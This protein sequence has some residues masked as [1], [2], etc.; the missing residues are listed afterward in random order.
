MIMSIP[1]DMKT[2]EIFLRTESDYRAAGY[3]VERIFEEHRLTGDS[4]SHAIVSKGREKKI[5]VMLRE[6]SFFSQSMLFRFGN[7]R[8]RLRAFPF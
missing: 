2:G 7:V 6:G 5:V 4:L 1:E 3:F 8:I